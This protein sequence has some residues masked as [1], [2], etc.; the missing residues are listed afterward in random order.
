MRSNYHAVV[1]N[2]INKGG[3][4][5]WAYKA[6]NDRLHTTR[7]EST[8]EINVPADDKPAPD[9]SWI[10]RKSYAPMQFDRRGK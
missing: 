3:P 6:R 2:M 7:C 10:Y 4:A 5:D 1:G 8:G 9:R